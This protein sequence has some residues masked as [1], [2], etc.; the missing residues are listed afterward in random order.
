MVISSGRESDEHA[1]CERAN[2]TKPTNENAGRRERTFTAETL[3]RG[4]RL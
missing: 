2:A 3:P 1:A 4:D